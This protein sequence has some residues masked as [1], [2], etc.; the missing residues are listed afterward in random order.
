MYVPRI[1]CLFIDVDAL[2]IFDFWCEMLESKQIFSIRIGSVFIEGERG[3][4]EKGRGSLYIVM[5][6]FAIM[7][8]INKGL[9]ILIYRV[10][11]IRNVRNKA[12]DRRS[13]LAWIASIAI[14]RSAI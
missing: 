7:F 8:P 11:E 12:E 9:V 10:K 6:F 1:G 4:G 3:A 13:D 5:A 14:N 2:A